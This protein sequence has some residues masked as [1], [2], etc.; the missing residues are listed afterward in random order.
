MTKLLWLAELNPQVQT[1]PLAMINSSSRNAQL[2][3]L[4]ALWGGQSPNRPKIYGRGTTFNFKDWADAC[5]Q[6]SDE[7]T[8]TNL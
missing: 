5:M 6:R 7:I 4:D 8:T 1:V 2:S 3:Q